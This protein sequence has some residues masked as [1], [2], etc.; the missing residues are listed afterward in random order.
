VKSKKGSKL[1]IS[2]AGKNRGLN[3]A[4]DPPDKPAGQSHARLAEEKIRMKV[5]PYLIIKK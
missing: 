2:K 5:S 3:K 4:Y 1:Q